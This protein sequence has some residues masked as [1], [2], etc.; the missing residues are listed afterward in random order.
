MFK[1][2]T[3]EQRSTELHLT[4]I[5]QCFGKLELVLFLALHPM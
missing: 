5:A 1:T 3:V 4:H 2:V